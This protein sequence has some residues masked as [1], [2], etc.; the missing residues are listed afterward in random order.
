MGGMFKGASGIP[1]P[2][3]LGP[4]TF[5]ICFAPHPAESQMGFQ[6]SPRLSRPS[7]PGVQKNV[8]PCALVWLL[9]P[10]R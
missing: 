5:A 2:E 1:N 7:S 4:G 8:N 10:G 3:F 9:R 6:L